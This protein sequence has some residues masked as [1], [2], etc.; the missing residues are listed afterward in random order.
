MA[1]IRTKRD[2]EKTILDNFVYYVKQKFLKIGT[3]WNCIQQFKNYENSCRGSITS[4]WNIE[5]LMN[6]I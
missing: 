3:R 1:L 6:Y 5:V 2:G 4:D